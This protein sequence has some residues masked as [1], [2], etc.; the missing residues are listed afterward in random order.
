MSCVSKGAKTAKSVGAAA[1]G[2]A[3]IETVSMPI[4][5]TG[6]GVSI[7]DPGGAA[8]ALVGGLVA[9]NLYRLFTS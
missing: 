4:F 7:T 5:M 2:Y 6:N 3:A 8:I 1:L 9:Y